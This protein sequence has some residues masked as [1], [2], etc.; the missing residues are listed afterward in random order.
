MNKASIQKVCRRLLL[1][2]SILVS[3]GCANAET[4]TGSGAGASREEAVD[5]AK[6]NV[7]LVLSQTC[8]RGIDGEISWSNQSIL[9]LGPFT[10]TITGTCRCKKSPAK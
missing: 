6:E 7:K 1:S 8:E 3:I 5:A 2:L 4:M 10:A 9:G